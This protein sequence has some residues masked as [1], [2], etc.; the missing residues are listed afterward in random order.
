MEERKQEDD[1]LKQAYVILC[2]D[3][4]HRGVI[5][6]CPMLHLVVN[7]TGIHLDD[8]TKDDGFCDRG[9]GKQSN[10]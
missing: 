2:K 9:E 6:R 5:Y 4:I 1:L 8:K 3:C 10:E 7:E